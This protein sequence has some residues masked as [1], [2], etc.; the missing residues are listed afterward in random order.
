MAP[1]KTTKN[2]KPKDIVAFNDFNK[3]YL[4][5]LVGDEVSIKEDGGWETR[6]AHSFIADGRRVYDLTAKGYFSVAFFLQKDMKEYFDFEQIKF[7]VEEKTIMENISGAYCLVQI[8]NNAN[9]MIGTGSSFQ[10]FLEKGGVKFA[11]QRAVTKATRNAYKMIIPDECVSYMI[12]KTFE[13]QLKKMK[14]TETV[15]ID[16]GR[17]EDDNVSKV[18][19]ISEAVSQSMED[20]RDMVDRLLA[21]PTGQDKGTKLKEFA[22]RLILDSEHDIANPQ[23]RNLIFYINT[24]LMEMN[25]EQ[26]SIEKVIR[27]AKEQAEAE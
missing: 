25:E 18:D 24:K 11:H 9:N 8:K 26:V 6:M 14:G 23:F 4:A 1:K 21:D 12:S 3:K 15:I 13:N 17:F 16:S 20:R 5:N 19:R 7:Y 22:C 10:S 2:D 27:K